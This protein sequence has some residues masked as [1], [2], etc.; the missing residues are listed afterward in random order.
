MVLLRATPRRTA[1]RSISVNVFRIEIA[2]A[3]GSRGFLVGV[4]GF[5][6]CALLGAAQ[7]ISEGL[8]AESFLPPGSALECVL[9]ALRSGF[10]AAALPVLASMPYSA[11]FV[12][13]R[14]GRFLR[15]YL[16]RCGR[17]VWLASR[18]GATAL[19]GG[20]TALAGSAV[21]IG[22]ILLIMLPCELRPDPLAPEDTLNLVQ[23]LG[24]QL[25]AQITLLALAAM[26]WAVTGSAAAALSMNRYLALAA[27]F[28]LYYVLVIISTRYFPQLEALNP[29]LWM[30]PSG[31][32]EG[33]SWAAGLQSL[34]LLAASCFLLAA[35][36]ERRTQDV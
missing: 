21:T 31:V 22:A 36:L 27:P 3:F 2:R 25:T 14:Q 11:S 29:K 35:V 5:A 30:Q 7:Q 23:T 28:I 12:E 9:R 17:R 24:G 16:P 18:V 15:S 32:W 19:V 10:L 13:E 20:G 1:D 6:L 8:S 33:V 34:N 4:A 26:L